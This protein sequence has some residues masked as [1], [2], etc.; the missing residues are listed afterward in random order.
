MCSL[1]VNTPELVLSLLC[2]VVVCMKVLLVPLIKLGF[3]RCLC[4]KNVN[5]ELCV[6][7]FVHGLNENPSVW[8]PS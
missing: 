6:A 7:T 3:M 5:S 1:N 2:M 8:Y 4:S